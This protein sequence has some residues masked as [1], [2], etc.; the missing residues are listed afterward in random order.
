MLAFFAVYRASCVKNS[1]TDTLLVTF[2]ADNT[3]CEIVMYPFTENTLP[4]AVNWQPPVTSVTLE[5]RLAIVTSDA[6]PEGEE[7]GGDVLE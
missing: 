6:F 5:G 2:V 7:K 4:R 3:C 1:D